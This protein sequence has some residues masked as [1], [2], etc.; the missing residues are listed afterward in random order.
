MIKSYVTPIPCPE[1]GCG[2]PLR[3]YCPACRGR[4]GGSKKTARKRRASRANVKK[5]LAARQR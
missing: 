4:L 5:A 1:P 3:A 2:H